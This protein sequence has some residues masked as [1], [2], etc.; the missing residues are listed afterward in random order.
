M[1][2]HGDSPQP[3]SE[4]LS[5]AQ[6]PLWSDE[7]RECVSEAIDRVQASATYFLK[8]GSS[9]F[10]SALSQE[11]SDR[12]SH[13]AAWARLVITYGGMT[14]VRR[15]FCGAVGD[16]DSGSVSKKFPSNWQEQRIRR[17]GDGNSR[18]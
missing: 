11:K 10:T 1:I 7:N 14:T 8:R 13:P 18:P 5:G 6:L 12:F 2:A 17:M 16:E 9:S 15:Y 4:V 3:C